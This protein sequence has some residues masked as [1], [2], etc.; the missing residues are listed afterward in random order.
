MTHKVLTQSQI[1]Q[2]FEPSYPLSE[3]VRMSDVL[4]RVLKTR[5][6][7]YYTLWREGQ[8]FI[9]ACQRYAKMAPNH[10]PLAAWDPCAYYGSWQEAKDDLL[11]R[12]TQIVLPG[13]ADEMEAVIEIY[14][15]VYGPETWDAIIKVDGW[16]AASFTTC[17]YIAGKCIAFTKS[18]HPGAMPG[19][20]WLNNGF[21]VDENLPDWTV[22]LAPVVTRDTPWRF[23]VWQIRFSDDGTLSRPH[24]SIQWRESSLSD[25]I[26]VRTRNVEE[27]LAMIPAETWTVTDTGFEVVRDSEWRTGEIPQF[28]DKVAA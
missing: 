22:R 24:L 11:A 1:D 23:H 8:T 25:S 9:L 10:I 4:N 27:L 16:P 7:V 2:I 26:D 20:V 5:D 18:R 21:T 6:G 19:G 3:D 13:P 12:K 28:A 15:F 17:S 14:R